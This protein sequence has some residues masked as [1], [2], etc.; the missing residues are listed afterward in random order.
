MGLPNN[1]I[2]GTFENLSPLA[3]LAPLRETVFRIEANSPT[4]RCP[5]SGVF[6]SIEPHSQMC[7][8][9]SRISL[10]VPST[11]AVGK[12]ILAGKGFGREARR[13]GIRRLSAAEV[14]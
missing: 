11:T 6:G 3:S 1:P 4:A 13:V 12:G 7:N 10:G 5:K 14:V 2:K 8:S 9:T